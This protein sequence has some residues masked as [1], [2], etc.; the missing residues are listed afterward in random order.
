[1]GASQG[2]ESHGRL[3]LKNLAREG[4]VINAMIVEVGTE[5]S[6][7]KMMVPVVSALRM[8]PSLTTNDLELC[9]FRIRDVRYLLGNVRRA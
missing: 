5:P 4:A 6:T 9:G 7:L 1:M 3:K 8:L 2:A